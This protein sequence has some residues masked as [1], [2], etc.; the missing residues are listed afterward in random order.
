MIKQLFGSYDNKY[1]QTAMQIGAYYVDVSND[2]VD[3]NKEK[4]IVKWKE[5]GGEDA[6]YLINS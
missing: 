2:T 6:V 3:I 5:N 4:V 1:F